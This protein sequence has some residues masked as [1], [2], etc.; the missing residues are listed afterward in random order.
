MTYIQYVCKVHQDPLC[1]A[2]MTWGE[3]KG[4]ARAAW[5]L[6]SDKHLNPLKLT[7]SLPTTFMEMWEVDL[8]AEVVA[9]A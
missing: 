1:I 2:P 5:C 4:E 3:S 6:M 8:A 7:V 9:E